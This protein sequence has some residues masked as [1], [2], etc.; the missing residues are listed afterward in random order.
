MVV[1]GGT[2]YVARV[3]TAPALAG[4]SVA[5]TVVKLPS[6]GLAAKDPV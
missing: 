3:V 2:S 6:G 5:L 4:V 1:A